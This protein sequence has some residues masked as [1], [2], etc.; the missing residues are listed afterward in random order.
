MKVKIIH[1][2]ANCIGCFACVEM[3]SGRWAMSKKDGKS[4]LL[5]AVNNKGVYNVDVEE[6]E[7]EEEKL[8][9]DLCP[10]KV[11]KIIK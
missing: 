11:I 9:A 7:Y 3:A 6:D 10:A 5:G 4:V 1:Y 8:V 2:R